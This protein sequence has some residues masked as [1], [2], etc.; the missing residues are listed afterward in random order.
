MITEARQHIVNHVA[1]GRRDCATIV[2]DTV[3]YLHGEAEPAQIRALAWGLV[4]PAFEAHLAAQAGW[5]ERTDN[6]RL[7]DAFQALDRA[8]IVAREEFS[9]CQNC[10]VAEIGGESESG[11]GYVFYHWQDAER[12]A[13]GGTLYLAYGLIKPAAEG[14]S[15]VR[16]GQEVAAALRAEGLE[17]VWDGSAGQRINVRMTWARRR[18]GR[19]AAY[20]AEDPA[21]SPAIE[22]EVISGKAGPGVGGVTPALQLERLVLPWLPDE[23]T[24]RLTTPDGRAIE[25]HREFDRLVDADG[26]QT[27]RFAGLSLLGEGEGE[28]D[29]IPEDGLLS[30]L[31]STTG[32]GC[33]PMTL[34]ETFAALRG[35]PCTRSWLSAVGRSGGCVQ[36]VWEE[37]RLWLETPDVEAAASFG[38]YATVAE[39][40]S[41]L[42]V[43]AEEDRVAVRDLAGVIAK[44]W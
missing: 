24:V 36:M 6:D 34:P 30:V 42:A 31:V 1:R 29:V 22:V 32:L 10:G 14:A 12:A 2:E 28:G 44:P 15:A 38:K 40:E 9:C 8:G 18:H 17:V 7:T 19:L 43:L 33:R 39:A 27:G 26:R 20:L 35:L 37:G 25:V 13:D 11:R 5:P 23:V 16:I 4:G 21:G 3:E 41:M